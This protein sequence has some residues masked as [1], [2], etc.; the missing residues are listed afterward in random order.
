M[1]LGALETLAGTGRT[2]GVITHVA[3]VAERVERVLHVTKGPG[4]STIQ[5]L[6]ESTSTAL[7]RSA[8]AEIV[9]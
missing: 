9:S 7:A 8:T 2:I 3:G 4:G 6:N 5:V 1:A